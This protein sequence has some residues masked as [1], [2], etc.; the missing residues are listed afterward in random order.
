MPRKRK[1][2]RLWYSRTDGQ[3]LILDNIDGKRVQVRTGCG[4]EAPGEAEQE[5]ANYTGQKH[6]TKIGE[7]SPAKLP[8][9]DVLTLYADV[10]A[11]TVSRPKDLIYFMKPLMAWWG[12]KVVAEIRGETCRAYA[13]DR[14]TEQQARRELEILRAAVNLYHK[15]YVLEYLPSITL[16]QKAKPR[17]AWLSKEE[18]ERAL[19]AAYAAG[20]DHLARFLLIGIYTGSRRGAILGL[21]WFPNTTSGYVDLEQGVMYRSGIDEKVADNKR[22]PPVRLNPKLLEHMK[23]WRDAD[24]PVRTMS[25][26]HPNHVRNVIHYKGRPV[27]DLRTSWERMRADAGLGENVTPHLLRHSSATWLMQAGV[28]ISEAAGFLGMTTET[29]ERVYSHHSPHFQ[30]NAAN[31]Y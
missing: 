30:E 15:E 7:H 29:L 4:Y 1:P 26:P 27:K 10:K 2:A 3:Y 13:R 21:Q 18:F 23:Q 9:A 24:M 17:Q 19:A 14:T 12:E 25:E 16:P 22:R 20:N 6:E 31:A 28:P 11:Q 5:L 8:I